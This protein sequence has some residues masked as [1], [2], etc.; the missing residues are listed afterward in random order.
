MSDNIIVSPVQNS[1]SV[2][3]SA[4]LSVSA[5]GPQGPQG[6]TGATGATGAQGPTGATGA[7][8]DTGATGATGPKGDTGATGAKG[9]TGATGATGPQGATGAT[10]ATGPQ[11][12]TGPTGATGSN[13]VG[14]PTGGSANQ[15]LAKID[16]TDYNTQWVAQSGGSTSV[17]SPITNSGTSSNPNIGINQSL[18]TIAESQVTNLSTDLSVRPTATAIQ[19]FLNQ[20]STVLDIYPR[21]A[22]TNGSIVSGGVYFSMFTPLVNQTVSNITYV[23]GAA[24]TTPT[25]VR[26]G[27]YSWDD[28]TSTATLLARTASD[29]TIFNAS[30]AFTRAFDTTGGYPASYTLQAGTRYAT[31][32]IVVA[33]GVPTIGVHPNGS[34]V[35]HGLLPRLDSYY[36]GA[37]DLPTSKVGGFTQGSQT[38]WARLT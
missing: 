12:P 23:S 4:S 26:F 18:L 3:A 33:T 6:A 27:L 19:Q 7:K 15:V 36:T 20:S 31:A 8:G 30:G 21:Y 9:D 22:T 17:T 29:T 13:G 32:Y 16:S 24:T 10:G 37:T 35:L 5:P 2:S 34:T 25:L 38:Y 1:L 11:G 14:V 28:S